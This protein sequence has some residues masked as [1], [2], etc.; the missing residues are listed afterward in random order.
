MIEAFF[1][2]SVRQVERFWLGRFLLT[3]VVFPPEVGEI[4]PEL[5]MVL[6]VPRLLG[7][8]SIP[9]RQPVLA[10][11]ATWGL[12][13]GLYCGTRLLRNMADRN[14]NHPVVLAATRTT[15]PSS[16]WWA[17]AFLCFG[18][19][20]LSALPLHC[21]LPAPQVDY[22]T[23]RPMWWSMDTYMTGASSVCLLV[24]SSSEP[25]T[26]KTAVQRMGW[27]LHI[28]G[29][30]CV[31]WFW[32]TGT[33]LGLERWYLY[34]PLLAG[35]PVC[36]CLY[37]RCHTSRGRTRFTHGH[38]LFLVGVLVAMLSICLDRPSCHLLGTTFADTFTA[39]NGV[40]FACDLCFLGI[41]VVLAASRDDDQIMPSRKHKSK[42][43]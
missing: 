1:P 34:P 11:S 2:A 4:C 5:V 6:V 29:L 21:L 20:N 3:D 33:S 40:F 19:M 10:V 23:E 8:K 15:R 31:G 12:V 43:V 25:S 41:Y 27:F 42:A 7:T 30:A 22:P 39:S 32:S 18:M 16:W 28:L 9:V 17:M 35:G 36:H 26:K 14:G 37:R 13:I 38:V 24:A